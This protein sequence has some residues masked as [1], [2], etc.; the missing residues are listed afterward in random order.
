M[1]F[2]V[3]LINA[4]SKKLGGLYL[5]YP[6]LAVLFLV[7]ALSLAGIPPLSGFWAKFVL[8]RAGLETEQYLI[9][10][11]ALGVSLL[12]LFSMTKIWAEVFWKADPQPADAPS[13]APGL[14]QMALL[15]VPI[16]IL[17]AFTVT[18]GLWAEPIFTLSTHAAEQLLN[19]T[20]YI[21]TVLGGTR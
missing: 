12:T 1:V 19:P 11:M 17:A 15:M 20:A 3:S 9:V 5:V 14:R 13:Q 10:A 8:V 16:I 2:V 4:A 7:P 6:G 18:I 21:N